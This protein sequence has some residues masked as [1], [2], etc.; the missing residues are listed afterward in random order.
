[1]KTHFFDP[2]DFSWKLPREFEKEDVR[3]SETVIEKYIERFTKVGDV[4]FD[5]FAGFGTT[6]LVA[7]RMNRKSFGLEIVS[8]R[9]KYGQTLLSVDTEL[10]TGDIRDNEMD[11]IP[12]FTL[13]ISSPPYMNKGDL[14]DPLSGYADT[15]RSY[16]FYVTELSDIY[17]KLGGKLKETGRIV[18]Q[19]QNLKN[20]SCLTPLAWDLHRAIGDRLHFEGE[21]ILTWDDFSY[22]YDHGYCL[23]Y[24]NV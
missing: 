23:I 11:T 10:V 12:E 16:E 17:V 14:E 6:L 18:I 1:M 8:E 13:S 24:S 22:G 20:S 2:Q 7:S 3:L 21:E 9:V 19:L 5:P 15:C 4:V